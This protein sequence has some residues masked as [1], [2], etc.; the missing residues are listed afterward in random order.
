MGDDKQAAPREAPGPHAG[1]ETWQ[2][3]NIYHAGRRE[4]AR[5]HRT[6]T[7]WH[8]ARYQTLGAYLELERRRVLLSTETRP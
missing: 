1:M 5:L 7:A 2:V 6:S 3:R 4:M 8:Q